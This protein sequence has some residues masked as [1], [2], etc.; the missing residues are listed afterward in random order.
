MSEETFL[1][2]DTVGP[3]GGAGDAVGDA[4]GRWQT[5]ADVKEPRTVADRDFGEESAEAQGGSLDAAEEGPVKRDSISSYSSLLVKLALDGLMEDRDMEDTAEAAAC[6][7]REL[8]ARSL[9]SLGGEGSEADDLVSSPE[10]LSTSGS[11]DEVDSESSEEEPPEQFDSAEE[12]DDFADEEEQPLEDLAAPSPPSRPPPEPPISQMVKA[13][14]AFDPPATSSWPCG[15]SP[16]LRF[17][18]G[19][20]IKMLIGDQMGWSYGRVVETADGEVFSGAKGYFPTSYVEAYVQKVSLDTPEMVCAK[21]DEEVPV[22]REAISGS[23]TASLQDPPLE[24]EDGELENVQEGPGI[25]EGCL[26]EELFTSD[27]LI[28]SGPLEPVSEAAE[29]LEA[30]ATGGSTDDFDDVWEVIDEDGDQARETVPEEEASPVMDEEEEASDSDM[31]TAEEGMNAESSRA[32]DYAD[33]EEEGEQA[34]FDDGESVGEE[35]AE[36]D[37]DAMGKYAIEGIETTEEVEACSSEAEPSQEASGRAGRPRPWAL[38]GDLAEFGSEEV[39]VAVVDEELPADDDTDVEA[40]WRAAEAETER[41]VQAES[42]AQD[43]VIAVSAATFTESS[44][45]AWTNFDAIVTP[46]ALSEAIGS[47]VPVEPPHRSL[48]AAGLA[49]CTAMAGG[50]GQVIGQP[51]SGVKKDLIRE[52]DLLLCLA[53]VNYAPLESDMHNRMIQTVWRKLT[54]SSYDCEVFGEHWAVIGFQGTNPATDLNRFGGILN[55]MHMLYL[56]SAVPDLSEAMYEASIAAHSDF[57]FACASIQYTKLAM[58]VFRSGRLSKRCNDKGAVLDVVAEFYAACFW[59]HCRVWVTE[60]RTIVDFDR[61]L[62]EVQKAAM[63]APVKVLKEFQAHRGDDYLEEDVTRNSWS[64]EGEEVEFADIGADRPTAGRR[65]SLDTQTFLGPTRGPHGHSRHVFDVKETEHGGECDPNVRQISGYITLKD[66]KTRYFFMFFEARQSPETAPMVVWINGGPGFSSLAGMVLENGPC[67]L[68]DNGKKT[69]LNP[70]SWTT[71][72]NGIWIDQPAATGFSTGHLINSTAKAGQLLSEFLHAFFGKYPQYNRK[73]F[74]AGE[75]YAG[76]FI[77]EAV[78]R[79]KADERSGAEP[80]IDIRGIAIG[81]GYFNSDRVWRSYPR[82][83]YESGTAPRRVSTAQ[84]ESMKKVAEECVKETPS[85]LSGHSGCQA[86]YDKCAKGLIN[87]ISDGNW[88]IYDLRTECGP[89]PDCLDDSPIRTYFNSPAV[90]KAIGAHMKWKSSNENVTAAFDIRELFTKTAE[91][92]L[93]QLLKS[94]ISVLLYA[95]EK[96]FLCNWISVLD[97]AEEL[98]WPGKR[99]FSRAP[100]TDLQLVSSKV[101]VKIRAVQKLD[102]FGGLTFARV[103]NASHM[104]PQDA[105]EAS[106]LLLSDF[107]HRTT[108]PSSSPPTALGLKMLI[109]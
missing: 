85:C 51:A 36:K 9:A 34:S 50:E 100:E 35:G 55:L 23:T 89:F 92:Q 6:Y 59:K 57:P 98:D 91:S 63:T 77:P 69:T 65:L 101:G 17:Q 103:I 90:Q 46:E 102:K 37:W 32:A 40:L 109:V 80:A 52:R 82:M 16:P 39:L 88:S 1:T 54:G 53:R 70:Y 27:R 62:K 5:F 86:L 87:P 49:C 33:G 45:W 66:N 71:E 44:E 19:D 95:G 61:T 75:S 107:I 93:V 94:E 104:V 15:D 99:Q 2:Y 84:Y 30:T 108:E 12:F 22:D 18:A 67:R 4:S 47:Y 68:V 58:D 28:G 105:P 26:G 41:R 3:R 8:T 76:K 81:N 64:D 79:M 43:G 29:W 42:A 14:F 60:G 13:T 96:D 83:A 97:T 56:Y 7:V 11:S 20:I 21:K 73:V 72:A 10:R 25:E 31:D 78:L 106:L 38:Q 48:S 74:M 24:E